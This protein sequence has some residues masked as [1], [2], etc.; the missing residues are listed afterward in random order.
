MKTEIPMF[1]FQMRQRLESAGDA[2]QRHRH[3]TGHSPDMEMREFHWRGG[4][5]FTRM[6]D[7]M[8]RVSQWNRDEDGVWFCD[9]YAFIPPNE[10]DSIVREMEGSP[11]LA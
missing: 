11:M 4:M 2:P 1:H 7:G 10:W 5:T 3:K 9:D 6:A 8:V